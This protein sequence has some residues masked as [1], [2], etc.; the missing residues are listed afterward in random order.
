MNFRDIGGVSASDGRRI[1]TGLFFRSALIDEADEEDVKFLKGL[2]LKVIFDY[3][4][5]DEAKLYDRG[6]YQKVGVPHR[7]L[8]VKLDNPKILKLKRLSH[9][10]RAFQTVSLE[11]VKETYRNMP[12]GNSSYK[13]MVGALLAGDVP[14]L[15]HCSAGKDRAGLGSAL[16][17]V[18]LGAGY[19]DILKDY[20][21]SLEYRGYIEQKIAGVL[22]K[23][24][25]RRI[26]K[27]FE[28]LFIV[29]K[30]LLDAAFE[31]I[32]KRY[33][34]IEEYLLKEYGLTKEIIA[35]LRDRY[36]EKI[37]PEPERRS[38]RS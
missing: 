24:I 9:I 2:G 19:D 26:I 4:D 16:L 5:E 29:D 28:P 6:V 13:E 21:V 20:M 35:E 18:V 27:K 25:A 7:N 14:L 3:R 33:G 34:T 15:Q 36:T 23:F 22:P 1:K 37:E 11:D 8:P 30:T 17:L 31:E 32:I 12:F 10:A 38:E